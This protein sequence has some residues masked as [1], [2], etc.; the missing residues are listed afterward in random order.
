MEND[1]EKIKWIF[2][3]AVI[4]ESVHA[5]A[6]IIKKSFSCLREAYRRNQ[7]ARHIKASIIRSAERYAEE[8]SRSAAN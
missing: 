3:G 5:A 2:I 8:S 1:F 7:E 4:V 6:S